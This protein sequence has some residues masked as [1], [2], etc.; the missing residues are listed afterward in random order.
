M[1][2]KSQHDV[3][4]MKPTKLTR[5]EINKLNFFRKAHNKYGEKYVYCGDYEAGDDL[6]DMN[7]TVHKIPFKITPEKHLLNKS[8]GCPGCNHEVR[9]KS[10][11]KDT[12][13]FIKKSQKIFPGRFE[14]DKVK[15]TDQDTNITLYC[16]IHKK[17][18]DVAPVV[19]YHVVSGGCNLCESDNRMGMIDIGS[20]EDLQNLINQNTQVLKNEKVPKM[21]KVIANCINC[22]VHFSIEENVEEKLC[23][24]C[25]EIK[26]HVT[27]DENDVA[28]FSDEFRERY[29]IYKNEIVKKVNISGL[30]K[31]YVSDIGR[32]FN[33]RL[34][35]LSGTYH[36]G[37]IELSL[38][39]NGEPKPFSLHRIICKVFHGPAPKPGMYVDHINRKRD[40]NDI[41]NLRWFTPSENAK[42]RPQNFQLNIQNI[43]WRL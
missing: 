22:N 25:D 36:Q 6:M 38:I 1:Y 12:P 39:H 17:D 41:K 27:F 15:Y 10:K 14:Y 23:Q 19:H 11:M 30:E 43:L 13:S 16:K 24:T 35:E 3:I 9:S 18:F 26:S 7:C 2:L 37:Y 42:I 33:A 29:G 20:K 31:Y 8:G 21:K 4:I 40:Q 5:K 32:I 28:I 34:N